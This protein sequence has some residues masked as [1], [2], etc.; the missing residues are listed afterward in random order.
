MI[1]A[2]TFTPPAAADRSVYAV[3]DT[4]SE[5]DAAKW[6]LRQAGRRCVIKRRVIKVERCSIVL[7]VVVEL[8][9]APAAEVSS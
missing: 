1:A 7:F 6:T 2:P 8:L 3:A 4:R 5:A 9:E